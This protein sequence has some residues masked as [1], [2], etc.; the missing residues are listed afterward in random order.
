MI[1][2]ALKKLRS[3]KIPLYFGLSIVLIISLALLSLYIE[4]LT[5]QHRIKAQKI[6]TLYNILSDLENNLIRISAENIPRDV[7]SEET[8]SVEFI[9]NELLPP[10]LTK[11]KSK[12]DHED[13]SNHEKTLFYTQKLVERIVKHIKLIQYKNITTD[14]TEHYFAYESFFDPETGEIKKGISEKERRVKIIKPNYRLIIENTNIDVRKTK[15]QLTTLLSYYN[16]LAKNE[17]RYLVITSIC[18]AIS[19]LFCI[20]VLF[21]FLNRNFHKPLE[22]FSQLKKSTVS[23]KYQLISLA[24]KNEFEDIRVII[25]NLLTDMNN[26]VSYTEEFSLKKL[27][28]NNDKFSVYLN[29]KS[30]LPRALKKMSKNLKEIAIQEE[31]RKWVIEST[32]KF[33]GILNKASSDLDHNYDKIINEIVSYSGSL[34]GALF[35]IETNEQKE[36]ILELKSVFAYDRNKRKKNTIRKGEGIVGQ[37]WEEKKEVYID[38]IPEDHIGIKSGLGKAKPNALLVFPIL[39]GDKLYG[40]IELASFKTFEE[41]HLEFVKNVS[42]IFATS[43]SSAETNRKTQLLLKESQQLAEKMR[44]QEEQ[45]KKNL[46]ALKATQEEVEKRELIKENQIDALKRTLKEKD[47]TFKSEKENLSNRIAELER[48][49]KLSL[50]DNDKIRNLQ[51][52]LS[53]TKEQSEQELLDLQETIKIKD[54]RIEKLRNKLQKNTN[55]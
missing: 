17:V 35:I 13:L 33:S 50:E 43:L 54:M 8:D 49:L 26:A 30:P 45:T 4:T 14:T 22:A 24:L 21:L 23:Q 37:C 10:S 3:N 29:S 51:S 11:D 53:Q 47:N 15:N 48:D 38:D 6:N 41:H 18:F 52:E 42:E 2:R 40:V 36:E 28:E 12:V 46:E 7:L 44:E 16:Q 25:N 31:R 39:E 9:F 32:A 1:K 55:E 20:Y 34:Q 27:D 5:P 19:C